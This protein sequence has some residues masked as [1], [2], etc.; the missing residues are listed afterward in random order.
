MVE[1]EAIVQPRVLCLKCELVSHLWFRPWRVLSAIIPVL[2]APHLWQDYPD[3]PEAQCYERGPPSR[4]WSRLDRWG[5][6]YFS[7]T[8][9]MWLPLCVECWT[10]HLEP[11]QKKTR[12]PS[13]FLIISLNSWLLD[14]IQ[15]WCRGAMRRKSSI[16]LVLCCL[17]L[18]F[19]IQEHQTGLS[20]KV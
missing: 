3:S 17:G 19:S 11:L 13:E 9:S 12:F 6:R 10:I 1:S 14:L 7:T 2:A 18:E 8:A 5:S 4:P 16:V 20:I 15:R